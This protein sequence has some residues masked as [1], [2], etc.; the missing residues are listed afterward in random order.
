MRLTIRMLA[1]MC[2][3]LMAQVACAQGAGAGAD[4]GVS[5]AAYDVVLVKPVDTNA[6]MT[7]VGVQYT[8]DG[9]EATAWL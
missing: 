7:M 2:G 5:F 1:G 9:I 8:A 4:A 3:L 6:R